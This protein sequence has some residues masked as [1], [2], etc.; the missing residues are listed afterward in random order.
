MK[1]LKRYLASILCGVM[2]FNIVGNHIP[3]Y[4]TV[5]SNDI[6]IENSNTASPSNA[7]QGDV[8]ELDELKEIIDFIDFDETLN[9]PYKVIEIAIKEKENIENLLPD[10]LKVKLNDES[11]VDIDVS[12]QCKEDFTQNDIYSFTFNLI[13]P[14]EYK[15]NEQLLEKINSG[16]N[17]LPFIGVTIKD[18]TNPLVIEDMDY[19]VTLVYNNGNENE[20]ILANYLTDLP[21]PEY[22]GYTFIDWYTD[23]E[24][25]IAVTEDDLDF[26]LILYAKWEK[27][28][29]NINLVYNN[30]AEN[31]TVA[32][33]YLSDITDP[34]YDG[35]V[36]TG[37]FTDEA[38]SIKATDDSITEGNTLYAGWSQVKYAVTLVYNNGNENGSVEVTSLDDI[39]EPTYD[40]YTFTGWYIDETCETLATALNTGITLYAGWEE[41][42]VNIAVQYVDSSESG[43]DSNNGLTADS[44]VK[45]LAKAYENLSTNGGTIYICS[46]IYLKDDTVLDG[47]VY[48]DPSTEVIINDGYEVTIKRFSNPVDSDGNNLFEKDSYTGTLLHSSG[49]VTLSNITIDGAGCTE[50]ID[51][52]TY[53]M[54][55]A[56]NSMIINEGNMTL[57]KVNITN[58]IIDDEDND[59]YTVFSDYSYSLNVVDAYIDNNIRGIYCNGNLNITNIE[60]ANSTVCG[61]DLEYNCNFSINNII[62]HDCS[63]GVSVNAKLSVENSEIKN[64]VAYDNKNAL[65]NSGTCMLYVHTVDI[66]NNETGVDAFFDGDIE[67]EEGKIYNN[68]YGLCIV[69]DSRVKCNNVIINSN[70]LYQVYMYEELGGKGGYF[71]MNGGEISG[72]SNESTYVIYANSRI[73]SHH[74][75]I[76]IN[77]GSIHDNISKST[78]YLGVRSN[79]TMNDGEIYN[80]KAVDGGAVQSI[81]YTNIRLLGGTIHDNEATNKG[82]AIYLNGGSSS[83]A[84]LFC[85]VEMYNNKAVYGGAVYV[86]GY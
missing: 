50:V 63:N 19:D 27:N 74:P 16:E 68:D 17:Y 58:H 1:R 30:G 2:I 42:L 37:W 84:N 62:I 10:T 73:S 24:C 25:T 65:S 9:K 5:S 46:Q 52:N 3:V 53:N 35:Y 69:D 56:T 45:T 23:E 80:N 26:G 81:G 67:I 51:N 57:D 8:S 47:T 75:H 70:K 49:D 29:V 83:G 66:Y 34:T 13:L 12:W 77:G 44:P 54:V 36:F 31:G 15:V 33:A 22:E 82:G 18:N 60:I 20:V 48:K 11:E 79:L 61:L 41:N 4:A 40:G 28:Q 6:T 71:Y 78:I 39:D 59:Y 72:H 14:N 85:E 38:L 21:I 32:A 86:N 76:Y 7:N 43:N 64:I 55:Y